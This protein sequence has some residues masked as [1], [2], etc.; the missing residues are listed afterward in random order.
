[1]MAL[2]FPLLLE[3]GEAQLAYLDQF[4]PGHYI[5]IGK[6]PGSKKTYLGEASIRRQQGEL[7]VVRHIDGKHFR[8]TARVE[9]ATPD[10][11]AV[12]RVRFSQEGVPYEETC[13]VGSDLDNYARMTCHLYLS[14]AG[15]DQPG[16]EAFFIDPKALR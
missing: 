4:L 3:A 15:T 16:L 10:D 12:L 8:G 9:V 14:G 13:L 7:V 2:M 5:V 11:V 1:M 6:T